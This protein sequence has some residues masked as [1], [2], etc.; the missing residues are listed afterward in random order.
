[1]A[2]SEWQVKMNELRDAQL[3]TQRLMELNERRWNERFEHMHAENTAR[4]AQ[5]EEAISRLEAAMYRLFE[6]IDQFIQ[7]KQSNGHE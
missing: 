2:N 6:H 7:G 3:V 5:H 1:M 4:F